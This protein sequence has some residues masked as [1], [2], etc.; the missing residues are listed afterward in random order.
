VLAVGIVAVVFGIIVLANIWGSVHL[1]YLRWL[2][3]LL[4]ASCSSSSGGKTGRIVAGIIAIIAASRLS[5]SR[6]VGQDRL[7]PSASLHLGRLG[8]HRYDRRARRGVGWSSARSSSPSSAGVIIWP[9]HGDAVDDPR[10][11]LGAHSASRRSSRR[12]L[13]RA[14]KGT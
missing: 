2:F 5:F 9:A 1:V 11:L 13:R 8:G 3:L 14:L 12:S 7:P 10:R 6:G 4:R